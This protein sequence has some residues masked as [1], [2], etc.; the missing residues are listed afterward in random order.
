MHFTN[1]AL[2]PIVVLKGLNGERNMWKIKSSSENN[3]VSQGLV[4]RLNDP[5]LSQ[6]AKDAVWKELSAK[7]VAVLALDEMV[8]R[9][10][11]RALAE[12]AIGYLQSLLVA[13]HP[14]VCA[15]S[16]GKDSNAS[17]ALMLEAMKRVK[18][19][20][21]ELPT[22]YAINSNTELENPALDEYF[23]GMEAELGVF[24]ARQGL[25]LEFHQVKPPLTAS[26]HYVTIGRGKLPRFPSMS[27]DCSVD[28]KIKPIVK[29]KK[30]LPKTPMDKI[31]VVGTRINESQERAIRMEERGD[32]AGEILTN[33]DGDKYCTPI[34]NWELEDVWGLLTFCDQ[35]SGNAMYETF[36]SS[37]D[38]CIELYKDA[39]GGG[40]VAAL[41][42]KQLNSSACGARFG[43]WACV[44]TGDTDKSLQSMIESNPEKY[45]WMEPIAKLRDWIYSLR[46]DFSRR[47]WLGR[48]IDE[49]TN[50]IVLT[51]DYL[52]FE[53]RR[54][55][56][57]Y[58]LTLDAE[59][60][61][62]ADEHNEEMVRFQLISYPQL[63]AIDFMWSMYRDSPHAFSALREYYLIRHC[64]RRYHLPEVIQKH[65]KAPVPPRRWFPLPDNGISPP[66]G[67]GGLY[68][69]A[70]IQEAKATRSG[71]SAKTIKD[72]VTGED[73]DL[74]P[75]DVAPTMEI[76][77]IE[78]WSIVHTYC[79]TPMAIETTGADPVEAVFYYLQNGIVKL[80]AGQPG[81]LDEMLQR[82]DFWRRLQNKENLLNIRKHAMDNSISDKEHKALKLKLSG[83]IEMSTAKEPALTDL[84]AQVYSTIK[85]YADPEEMVCVGLAD[86]VGFTGQPEK[87]LKEAVISLEKMK[88]IEPEGEGDDVFYWLPEGVEVESRMA[89]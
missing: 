67:I 35:S 13:G 2:S 79:H 51:P 82:A 63:V 49:Q 52:D 4:S 48:S 38:E 78:A 6:F 8:M 44:A 80:S 68:D 87:A 71:W 19:A 58:M 47:E 61:E 31:S 7:R 83:V 45:G 89:S 36:V 62:W 21:G 12:E 72:R 5:E 27:R 41:G 86:L 24:C 42:D 3:N 55:M 46:Y 70:R 88:L 11:V 10:H 53:T 75:F 17:L 59:E 57:R 30:K 64:G 14:L 20:G 50:H 22:C 56:L 40:C 54:E 65:E 33:Q 60:A 66:H 73:K 77:T 39:N 1:R 9:H 74:V 25:P 81:S 16:W 76:D 34:A 69:P 43:C 23:E 85:E 37:F 32:K 15:I 18:E 28:W 26:F 84:E 29:A